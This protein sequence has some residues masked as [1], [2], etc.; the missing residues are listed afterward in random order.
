MLDHTINYCS[1]GMSI[2]FSLKIFFFLVNDYKHGHFRYKE[3]GEREFLLI[4]STKYYSWHSRPFLFM[5]ECRLTFRIIDSVKYYI[6]NTNKHFLPNILYYL[7]C[8]YSLSFTFNRLTLYSKC[9]RL[10]LAVYYTFPSTIYLRLDIHR[11]IL[12][13][14]S[15][16]NVK[17]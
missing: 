4:F 14:S 11:L 9:F 7:A 3:F 10:L 6:H 16:L 5:N 1:T 15:L 12:T 2:K 8:G 17:K 13:G